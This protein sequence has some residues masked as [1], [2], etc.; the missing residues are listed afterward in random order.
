MD[1]IRWKRLLTISSSVL[2]LGGLL[3]LW[4]GNLTELTSDTA[5]LTLELLNRYG[6]PISLMALYLEESGVPL[7]VPGDVF[8]L[9]VGHAS[10][11]SSTTLIT[12]WLG[13][14][15]VVVAG[16]TNLYLISRHYGR[17]LLRH[18][19]AQLVGLTADSLDRAERWF[20]RW[21]M[22]AIV[23]G[24]HVPG[25]RIAITIVAGTLAVRYRKFAP[26]VCVSAAIWVAIWMYL[27]IEVWRW[28]ESLLLLR[29]LGYLLV[30]VLIL[31]LALAAV[32]SR[33]TA[34]IRKSE[35]P[36]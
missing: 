7:P 8:V 17:R 5:R 25:L 2:L 11:T 9:Y 10:A 20:D 31:A 16:S 32:Y 23:I 22:A 15:A 36:S 4:G 12:V 33:G 6:A 27:G 13:L 14:T 29:R 34:R 28:L 30:P 21:G 1:R 3:A 26:A 24:R 18:R 19:L 35:P